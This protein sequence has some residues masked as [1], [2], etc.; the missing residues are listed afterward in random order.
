M[1]CFKGELEELRVSTRT[2]EAL[3]FAKYKAHMDINMGT[4]HTANYLGEKR[5]RGMG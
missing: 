2:P 4:I 1:P 3:A 5:M